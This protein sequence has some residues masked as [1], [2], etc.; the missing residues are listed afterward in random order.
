MHACSAE[1][2]SF[3]RRSSMDGRRPRTRARAADRLNVTPARPADDRA[4]VLLGAA[5][6]APPTP[7]AADAAMD[8]HSA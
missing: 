6:D 1:K 5:S 8:P 2:S 4:V 7:G 3:L